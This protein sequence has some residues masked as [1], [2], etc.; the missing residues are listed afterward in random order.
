TFQERRHRMLH[1]H[2]TLL[3]RI[4]RLD[5]GAGGALGCEDSLLD[6]IELVFETVQNGEVSVHHRIHESVEN[7]TGTLLQQLRLSFAARTNLLKALLGVTA[8]RQN[9]VW[10]REDRDLTDS[11]FAIHRLNHVQ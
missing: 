7:I 10:A 1:D 9:I 6:D 5:V 8:Y 4:Q 3:E 11:K 2:Q